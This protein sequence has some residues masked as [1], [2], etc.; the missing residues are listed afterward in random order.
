MIYHSRYRR[1]EQGAT[2]LVIV[3]FAV[4]LFVT[5]TVGFMKIMSLEQSRS[6]DSE[7]SQGAYDSALAGVEDGKR[8][9]A[10]CAASPASAACTAL[11]ASPVC[12]TVSDANIVKAQPNGEV[13]LKTTSGTNGTD[14]QQSYTCVKINRNTADYRGSLRADESNVVPLSVASTD[15]FDTVH[16]YWYAK[17]PAAPLKKPQ[18]SNVV[19]PSLP[20][21]V[22]WDPSGNY[23]NPPIMRLQ[24]IQFTSN[25]FN[26]GDFD[27]N[28]ASHTLYLYPNRSGV[29]AL[30]FASDNRRIG[31]LAP[32]LVRCDSDFINEGYAC[33]ATITVPDT[34]GMGGDM[35]ER[36]AYLRVT[37][38]Y[39]AA[40]Y[41]IKLERAGGV[42]NFN[43]VQPSI[44]STGRAADVFRRVDARVEL[45]DP[46]ELL[47]YPRATVD[48][49]QN[50]C[51]TFIVASDPG[52]YS[53]G[54]CDPAKP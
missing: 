24:L 38:A 21:Y 36:R 46:N 43:G 18:L 32:A 23:A 34:I 22:D 50:F 53:A 48:I 28:G 11:A 44:D 4:L 39:N 8:V 41:M 17:D 5:L 26:P 13:Y 15:F 47:L 29:T 16:F 12:T 14:F 30:G 1:Y 7:L 9:L 51:K 6:N 3:I 45:V 25:S 2:A 40:D 35:T 54:S 52:D 10:A 33:E 27:S 20:R 31:T 42:V 19:S 49:T 37:T